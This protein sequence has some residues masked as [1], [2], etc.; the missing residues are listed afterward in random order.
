MVGVEH[1][2]LDFREHQNVSIFMGRIIAPES[3]FFNG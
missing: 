3:K 2:P 1:P